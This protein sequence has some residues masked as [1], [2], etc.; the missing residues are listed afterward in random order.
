MFQSRDSGLS[1]YKLYDV[2]FIC[3]QNNLAPYCS[4]AGLPLS[5]CIVRCPFALVIVL[6]QCGHLCQFAGCSS[7]RKAFFDSQYSSPPLSILSC[8]VS[9]TVVQ[10]ALIQFSCP[11][12]WLLV[13]SEPVY[14]IATHIVT[15]ALHARASRDPGLRNDLAQ[16]RDC[17]RSL[18]NSKIVCAISRL[19]RIIRIPKMRCAIPGLRKFLDCAE[20]IYIVS[21]TTHC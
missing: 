6:L 19:L 16:S 4:A 17:T 18:R 10:T 1:W 12:R 3:K 11:F 2:K 20:H 8:K 14:S 21:S 7:R 9:P 5:I 13:L 15:R